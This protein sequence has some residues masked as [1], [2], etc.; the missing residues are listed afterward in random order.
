M[1]N[2]DTDLNALELDSPPSPPRRLSENPNDAQGEEQD[3]QPRTP[4]YDYACMAFLL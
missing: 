4:Y 2:L 1:S 3:Q